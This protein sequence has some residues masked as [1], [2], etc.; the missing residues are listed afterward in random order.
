MIVKTLKVLL[1]IAV[2]LI[3]TELLVCHLAIK[4]KPLETSQA[5]ALVN[6]LHVLKWEL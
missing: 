4:P 3:K 6:F 2:C 1:N 5:P